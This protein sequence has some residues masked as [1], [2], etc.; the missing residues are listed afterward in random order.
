M[1]KALM[2]GLLLFASGEATEPTESVSEAQEESTSETIAAE[3][4][5]RETE[6]QVIYY[7]PEENSP[8]D[9]GEWLKSVFT[10]EVI[11]AIISALTA[12]GAL[13][14]CASSV[15]IFAKSK[16]KDEAEIQDQVDKAIRESLA[17]LGN[18]TL[19]PLTEKVN[20]MTPTLDAFA[21][22][23]ALSDQNTPEA[24]IARLE[25]L[26]KVGGK[27]TKEIAQ[28][29]KDEVIKRAEESKER[30]DKAKAELDSIIGYD[31]TRI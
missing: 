16:K 30:T 11:A 18:E 7:V 9:F 1:I 2:A 21:K 19:L 22:V 14:K 12:A 6:P 13:L 23:L 5:E 29:A 3:T 24:K 26:Q 10:P 31:G 4:T 20:Q 8:K 15:K 28:T 17:K 25:L 27:E